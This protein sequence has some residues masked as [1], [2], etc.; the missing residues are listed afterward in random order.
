MKLNNSIESIFETLNKIN[1]KSSDIVTRILEKNNRKVGYIY[2][3]SVSSD[4]KISDFLNK[5]LINMDRKKPFDSFYDLIQN[6]IFNSKVKTIETYEDMYYHLASGFTVIVIDKCEKAI[7]VET[8]QKLDRGVTESTS[9]TITRGPKD[10]FTENH[11]MNLG[12]IRKRIKDPNLWYEEVK[13]GRRSKSKVTVAYIKDIVPNYKVE[14]I[15]NE[16]KKVD[17]DAVIDTGYIREL[18]EKEQKSVFPKVISTERPDLAC[19]SLLDGKIVILVEN[20]PFVIILPAVLTDFFKSPEDNYQK[21]FNVSFSRILRVICFFLALLTP[22]LYIALMTFNQEIIPDQLLISLAIQRDGVPFPTAIEVLLFV[23]T[24][25]VLR[26]ADIHSPSFS[27]SA[28][29]V[30]GALILGDA[31]VAAGIVSPIVVIIVAATSISELVFYDVDVIDAIRE[32]RLLFIIASTFMGLVGFVAIFIMFIAKL[33]SLECLGTPYLTPFSPLNIR[34]LKDSIIRVTRK[35]LK[36]RPEY[37]TKNLKRL[38]DNYE[39]NN[40]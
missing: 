31:A 34:S 24:F 27:G 7:V 37:L 13:V 38:D 2:L 14:K 5:A 30:V 23:L 15:L 18:L 12:L 3:E 36:Q 19:T 39:K 29:N 20:S 9:E 11:N 21:P 10:S 35:K 25:E 4:D 16:L 6:S 1:G 26:E 22:A 33:S 40:C 8:R 17:I 32:W 28:M